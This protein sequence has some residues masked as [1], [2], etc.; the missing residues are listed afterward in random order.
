MSLQPLDTTNEIP[1]AY[2]LALSESRRW[3]QPPTPNPRATDESVDKA[4]VCVL[5]FGGEC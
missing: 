5:Y 3:Y 1:D 2:K 4:V